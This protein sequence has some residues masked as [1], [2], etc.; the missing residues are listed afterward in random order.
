MPPFAEQDAAS[1]TLA[2]NRVQV[3][4][5]Y[6]LRHYMAEKVSGATRDRLRSTPTTPTSTCCAR[7][8]WRRSGGC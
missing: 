7:K 6:R 2:L 1:L 8:G 3:D 5:P 4:L